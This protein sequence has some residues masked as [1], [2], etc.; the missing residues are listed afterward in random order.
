MAS[1]SNF[2]SLGGTPEASEFG[3]ALR[4]MRAAHNT[5]MST[6]ASTLRI[7]QVY[8][9]AIE[10]GR[11]D[12]LPG[13]TYAAGFVRAYAEYLGLDISETMQRYRD[14]T[15]NASAQAP[16]VAPSPVVEGRMPTGFILLVAAVLAATAYGSWYYLSL[17][18]RDAGDLV[19]KLPQRIADM[20]GLSSEEEAKVMTPP[21]AVNVPETV[22][23]EAAPPVVEPAATAAAAEESAAGRRS[24]TESAPGTIVNTDAVSEVAAAVPS[25]MSPAPAATPSETDTSRQTASTT[26]DNRAVDNAPEEPT[27][28]SND[29]P[30][31]AREV[32]AA[33]PVAVAPVTPAES[34]A[35]AIE[36]VVSP[37]ASPVASR[38]A[39]QAEMLASVD[40]N[41]APTLAA[42]APQQAALP[43]PPA[44]VVIQATSRVVLRA[45][46]ISWVEL[47]DVAGK[48]VFSRLLK[49]GEI[50]NVPAQSG[51]TLATGNAGALD[52][53][54]DGQVISPIGPLG[55][56]RRDVL[57][58]P[59]A[60]LERRP[61]GR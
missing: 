13:P 29:Q 35:P 28:A 55:A 22:M 7:R 44:T 45:T 26:P 18:G 34:A 57:L 1:S 58:E 42:L 11:F 56:V 52:I 61:G 38:V 12:D 6:V 49:K 41:E 4:E 47:R 39:D 5:D 46:A 14:V 37:A 3:A 20:V 53:L 25:E 40:R 33:P 8:L 17:N 2:E 36:S 16:L 10:D 9:E 23:S 31:P 21:P 51:I 50:Y 30:P 32:A 54:V 48:R 15:G 19:A 59:G 43:E 27:A 24:M 60:L